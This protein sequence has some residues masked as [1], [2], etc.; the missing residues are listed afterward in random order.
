MWCRC[1]P[2]GMT[3]PPSDETQRIGR[4][5]VGFKS[6]TMRLGDDAINFFS[7]H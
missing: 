2:W 4:F 3:S 5:G 1:S 7:V 6:G